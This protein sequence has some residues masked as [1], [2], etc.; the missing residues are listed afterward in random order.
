MKKSTFLLLF[1]IITIHVFAQRVSI[2]VTRSY[3]W[4]KYVNPTNVNYFP[5]FSNVNPINYDT[6]IVSYSKRTAMSLVGWI[7]PNLV[8]GIASLN[9]S[10]VHLEPLVYL[11][12]L[13]VGNSITDAGILH[14]RLLRNLRHFEIALAGVPA[15]NIT[16]ESMGVLGGLGN[17]EIL[18]L[19]FCSRVSDL[20]LEQLARLSKLKELTLNGCGI[21]DKGLNILSSFSK[22]ETLGLAATAIDDKGVEMLIKLLPS[23]PAL[24]KIIISNSKITQR[25]KNNLI[26]S[27]KGL[28][29]IY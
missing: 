25:G 6:G 26:A 24:K 13:L 7:N 17:M 29:V 15:Y 3:N 19:Y 8:S 10:L 4:G 9:D 20:G 16:D 18:R 1:S 14:L 28:S 12:Q 22:L 23:L 2:E 5:T 11:E 21:T 27:G